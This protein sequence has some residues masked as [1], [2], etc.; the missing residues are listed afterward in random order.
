M[1]PLA[2]SMPVPPDVPDSE[3]V[4]E[5]GVAA[6]AVPAAGATERLPLAL[7]ARGRTA[8]VVEV[9]GSD[10]VAQRLLAAG[11]WFGA[12]IESIGRAPFG[13]PLLFRV[14]GYRLALRRSEAERVLVRE[15]AS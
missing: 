10:E 14:H 13:D 6:G 8:E 3:P 9:R 2:A 12:R 7:L 11:I 15:C 4:A 1:I 5:L